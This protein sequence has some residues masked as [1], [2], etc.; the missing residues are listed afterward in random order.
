MKSMSRN[1]LVACATLAAGAVVIAADNK[2][3][4]RYEDKYKLLWEQNMFLKDRRAPASRYTSREGNGG[5]PG[6]R[7]QQTPEQMY[8]LRGVALEESESA[9]KPPQLHAYFEDTRTSKMVR[10]AVGE[11]IARGKIAAVDI[12]AV[13]YE[14]N[15][16]ITWVTVGTDLSGK[17]AIVSTPSYSSEPTRSSSTPA[18]STATGTTAS[19]TGDSG[20]PAEGAGPAKDPATMSFE[21]IMKQRRLQG[22]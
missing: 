18:T 13:A 16:Q 6:T 1:L 2:P 15:G 3:P 4:E 19:G 12:D 8:A 17:L 9:D 5:V 20:T 14:V 11:S 10:V 21:E 22:K 7:T